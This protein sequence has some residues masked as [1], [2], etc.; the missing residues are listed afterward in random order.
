MSFPTDLS[1]FKHSQ[2][3]QASRQAPNHAKLKPVGAGA[4]PVAVDSLAE[5]VLDT[6]VNVLDWAEYQVGCKVLVSAECVCRLSWIVFDARNS[7]GNI[8]PEAFV[9]M[10]LE[11]CIQKET[12]T[13]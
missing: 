5:Q 7:I 2:I 9:P 4:L 6:A 3:K 13:R 12:S 11:T 1:D 8:G 10:M